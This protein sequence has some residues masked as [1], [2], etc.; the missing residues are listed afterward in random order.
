VAEVQFQV[1][2]LH[3]G[4]DEKITID[5]MSDALE[6][7][8]KGEVWVL[9]DEINTC[10]HLG[11]LAELISNRIFQGKPIHPNI[12]LFATCNPYR[13][14]TQDEVG[15][16]TNTKKYKERN[17]I[18][19]QVKP[20]PNQIL[21]YTWNY[22]V[23]NQQDEY[24]YIQIMV[25]D[26]LKELALPVLFD[27]LFVSQ[28]FIRKFEEPCS[29]SLRDVKRAIILV[30]F[31]YNTLN[32]RPTYKKALPDNITTITRSY[33]LALSLCYHFRLNEQDLRKQYRYEIGQVFQNHKTFVGEKIFVGIIREEQEDYINRM[34]V[35]SNIAKND[36]LLENV[37][38]MI[39]CI[40][41]KIPIFVI[42][43]A[44]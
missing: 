40:L 12:R 3:A 42:G 7:A 25:K 31:F 11:L 36:A 29:V 23:L 44:G 43:E 39:V 10:N 33:V 24:K 15:R 41:N 21:D 38:V 6:K 30:K 2:N 22:G 14:R 16:T 32:N 1:L 5:F 28:Q 35:P 27:L 17:D 34:Q 18:V 20:L 19:Y 8:D 37:L 26:E 4:I 9:F 13:L